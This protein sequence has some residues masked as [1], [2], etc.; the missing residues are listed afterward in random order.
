MKRE[1]KSFNKFLDFDSN[2]NILYYNIYYDDIKRVI[3]IAISDHE[4]QAVANE[5]IDDVKIEKFDLTKY[6]FLMN[7]NEGKTLQYYQ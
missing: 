1:I 6:N 7:C 2:R 5:R 4:T 3:K